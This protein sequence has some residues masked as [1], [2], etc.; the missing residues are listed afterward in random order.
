MR[1]TFRFAFAALAALA[2]SAPAAARAQRLGIGVG[3]TSFDF[4]LSTLATN[5]PAAVPDSIYVPINITPTFRL[6]PQLGVATL[7][8]DTA[9]GVTSVE[10]SVVSLG[11]GL[12]FLMPASP[13]FGAYAGGRVVRTSFTSILKSTQAADDKTEGTDLR[14]IPA[15]GGE[16][17][18]HPR[19][20]LGAEVQ[21]QL[22]SFG[23]RS[24]TS[25]GNIP[26]GSGLQT[27][28]LLFARAYLF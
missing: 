25:G 28:A 7:K 1:S 13:E 24:V 20:S 8:Q 18:P 23:N 21:L 6:E 22:V 15:A 5:F 19:F 12:F 10:T 9:N 11:I 4:N 2:L 16:W 14:I 27:A 17:S 3:L 26:G